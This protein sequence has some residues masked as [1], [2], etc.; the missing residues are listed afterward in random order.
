LATIRFYGEAESEDASRPFHKDRNNQR[1]S[2]MAIMLIAL[3]TAK[4]PLGQIVMTANASDQLA[5]EDIQQGLTRHAAGDWGEV[6]EGDREEN[7][8]SLKEGFRLL[9]VYRSGETKF[10][11]IT[12]RDRSVTTVLMPEDY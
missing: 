2:E 4:F 9:S 6:C 8:L 11:I 7:E 5:A 12:E 10:W 1:S 3:A